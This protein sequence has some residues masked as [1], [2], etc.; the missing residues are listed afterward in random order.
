M[1]T[2]T[3]PV[4]RRQVTWWGL[5]EAAGVLAGLATV[6][7]LLGRVGWAFELVSHFQVQLA[8]TFAVLGWLAL[9]GRRWGMA[10]LMLIGATVNA[11]P[12]S[13]AARPQGRPAHEGDHLVRLMAL[14]VHT[15]NTRSDLVLEAVRQAD[16][17]VLLLLEVNDRWM[18]ELAPLRSN[19]PVVLAEPRPDNF[20]LALL[21]RWP[22]RQQEVLELG[23]VPV[24][25][26]AVELALSDR[27]FWLLGTHPVPPGSPGEAGE[28]NHQLRAIADWAREKAGPTMVLGDLNATPWSP[29]FRDLLRDSGLVDAKPAWG[30]FTT[31]PAQSWMLRL[32]LDH[33]L[34]SPDIG[35][36][37]RRVGQNTGSDHLP[38]HLHL[39][40]PPR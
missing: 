38:I 17:D 27:E 3:T 13:L 4:P 35:V 36:I 6:A 21:S 23:E 32:P 11:V 19:Y 39:A 5:V 15:A 14:N 30:L 1:D 16:P 2:E 26:L 20:G 9:L 33:C 28:R 34:V 12:V 22:I 29:Y 25:S 7:G 37:A 18:A 31:W 40:I 24:P 10:V 8:V